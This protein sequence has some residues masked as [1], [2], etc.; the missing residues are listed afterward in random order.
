M[1][2]LF[3][4][5]MSIFSLCATL[6]AQESIKYDTVIPAPNL[7]KDE[8]F[9]AINNWIVDDFKSL[10]KTIELQDKE[11]GMIII[12]YAFPYSYGKMM[13]NSYTGNIYYKL[14][15]TIRDGRF[16]LDVYDLIHVGV[17]SKLGFI[18]NDTIPPKISMISQK[19][20]T[21]AWVHVKKDAE[22][23]TKQLFK[24][25]G[26]YIKNADVKKISEEDDW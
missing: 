1:R 24:L 17:S 15:I 9:L 11:G 22:A 13:Y 4:M 12:H 23:K 3:L 25:I 26:D 14:K 8:L 21:K 5:L 19:M 16:K 7:N 10:K 6:D 2:K 20:N 18:T